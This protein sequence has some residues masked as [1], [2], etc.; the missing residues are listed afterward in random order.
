MSIFKNGTR[1]MSE[2]EINLL[3]EE[4]RYS[5]YFILQENKTSSTFCFQELPCF[6]FSIPAPLALRVLNPVSRRSFSRGKESLTALGS[7]RR[8]NG[9]GEIKR[10]KAVCWVNVVSTFEDRL[11]GKWAHGRPS[12]GGVGVLCRISFEKGAP[13]F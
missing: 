10:S 11:G 1:K 7:S 12:W 5:R 8:G 3:V 4:T 2:S 9:G 13:V 6:A